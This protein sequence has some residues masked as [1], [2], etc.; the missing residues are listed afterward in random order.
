L[1]QFSWFGLEAGAFGFYGARLPDF[2]TLGQEIISRSP[3]K[4]SETPQPQ[5][6]R[7]QKNP[8]TADFVLLEI[9]MNQTIR[10][11]VRAKQ[12]EPQ[13]R[14]PQRFLKDDTLVQPS[15]VRP[16]R[17]LDDLPVVR[18]YSSTAREDDVRFSGTLLISRNDNVRGSKP[19]DAGSNVRAPSTNK[20]P[21]PN[22]AAHRDNTADHRSRC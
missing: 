11:R 19:Y 1:E 2:G 8:R 12:K 5:I 3:K 16:N 7:W 15:L 22:T 13:Q 4:K 21:A 6:F 9:R 17:S 14:M 18:D 10:F 20:P